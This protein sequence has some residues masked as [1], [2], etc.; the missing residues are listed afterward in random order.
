MF[1]SIRSFSLLNFIVRFLISI[2]G[3][4]SLFPNHL[5]K[6][7]DK[8]SLSDL[9]HPV[10]RCC[11]FLYYLFPFVTF[12]KISFLLS[13]WF[14]SYII[15]FYVPHFQYFLYTWWST[16]TFSHILD[17]SILNHSYHHILYTLF[18]F[19]RQWFKE[20]VSFFVSCYNSYFSLI[21]SHS[22]SIYLLDSAL[23][24]IIIYFYLLGCT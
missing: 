8:L 18:I 7:K 2:C 4:F 24:F 22:K 20:I 19:L 6:D 16:H 10:L 12:P 3:G 1:V 17:Q 11:Y 9:N 13:F 23:S 14:S 21:L 15:I 5:L